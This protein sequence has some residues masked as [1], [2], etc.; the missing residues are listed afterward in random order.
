MAKFVRKSQFKWKEV[1]ILKIINNRVKKFLISLFYLLTNPVRAV[2]IMS[3]YRFLK[4]RYRATI[5]LSHSY[6][7]AF[8][9][10]KQGRNNH[11]KAADFNKKNTLENQ[12]IIINIH[13]GLMRSGGLTDRLKGICTL[14]MFAKKNN[15]KFK[16][17]FI[18][19]FNLEKYLVPNNYD[20]SIEEDEIYYN[21]T[22]TAIYTWENEKFAGDFFRLNKS[23]EQ[24]HVSCNS[25]ECFNH[26]SELFFELFKP[27]PFLES[28][29]E[30]HR[31]KLGGVGNYISMSFRFQNLLGEFEEGK[32]T[33]LNEEKRKFLIEKCLIAVNK[34]KLKHKDAKKILI[35][36]DSNIFREIATKTYAYIYTYILPEE[37]GHIDFADAGKGKELTAFMDMFLIAGAEKA[38]QIRSAEM[39][40]SDFPKMAAKI[41][42]VPYEMILI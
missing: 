40:N 21:L 7:E 35:T 2:K 30:F 25:G 14:Y 12:Q 32:S 22:K 38:Y 29:I 26:Y 16:I 34:I 20:W 41:N 31:Q 6:R 18:Y 9:R 5:I 24:L 8:Y 28:K 42:N 37:V 33:A 3:L 17:Y 36:S 15:F 13:D 19:P 27:S 10:R 4:G 1:D 23:K 39:Y 11:L